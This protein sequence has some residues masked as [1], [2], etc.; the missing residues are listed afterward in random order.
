M[1]EEIRLSSA[2]LSTR[3]AISRWETERDA[4]LSGLL[5]LNFM[6]SSSPYLHLKQNRKDWK[7]KDDSIEGTTENS[8]MAYKSNTKTLHHYSD[9]KTK[10]PKTTLIK[11]WEEA[12]GGSVAFIRSGWGG[13]E[14]ELGFCSHGKSAR[15]GLG[16]ALLLLLDPGWMWVGRLQKKSPWALKNK[17]SV[18]D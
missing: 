16:F 9:Q 1:R 7:K 14:I 18:S 5:S 12:A 3:K 8:D 15:N 10:R 13:E 6:E 17:L 4:L 11:Y 2:G